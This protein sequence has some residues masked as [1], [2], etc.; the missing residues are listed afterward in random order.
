MLGNLHD[1]R[2]SPPRIQRVHTTRHNAGPQRLKSKREVSVV[3]RHKTMMLVAALLLGGAAL[4]LGLGSDQALLA[5][6]D[7]ALL[8]AT[9]LRQRDRDRLVVVTNDEDV[10]LA[11]GRWRHAGEQFLKMGWPSLPTTKHSPLDAMD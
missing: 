7:D 9:V 6:L 11:G 10:A 3:S 8:H 5:L 2:N 4:L 1:R